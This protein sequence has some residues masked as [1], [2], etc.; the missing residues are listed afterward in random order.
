MVEVLH[1]TSI[2]V[3]DFSPT[4]RVGALLACSV[5]SA[6]MAAPFLIRKDPKIPWTWR[7]TGIRTLVASTDP[8]DGTVARFFNGCTELGAIGDSVVDKWA[9]LRHEFELVE[10]GQLSFGQ[11]VVRALRDVAVTR[12]R[13]VAN[14]GNR[15][16]HVEIKANR[17]GKLLPLY[18]LLRIYF[19]RR[20]WANVSRG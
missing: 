20:R 9:M 10:R 11:F 12:Q 4:Q 1:R 14:K 15:S 18:D 17:A 19:L 8:L 6:R 2:Q 16:E 7:D 13:L 5:T 3:A